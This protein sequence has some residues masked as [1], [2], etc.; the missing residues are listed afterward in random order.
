[1]PRPF[2]V[3]GFSS[4]FVLSLL[5]NANTQAAATAA[6]LIAAAFIISIIIGPVRRARVIP[7][8]LASCFVACILLLGA[9]QLEYKPSLEYAD[10]KCDLV[11]EIT[12][13]GARAYGRYYYKARAVSI[14]GKE[15]DVKIRLCFPCAL[16]AEPYDIVSGKFN[17]YKLG[18]SGEK[19]SDSLRASRVF[20][21]AY[22]EGEFSVS[23]VSKGDKPLAYRFHTAREAIKSKVY[24]FL[25]NESGAMAIALLLGDISGISDETLA[26][27][28]NVG[29]SHII[30]V[31][32]IHLSIWAMFLLSLAKKLRLGVKPASAVSGVIV[33]GYMALTGFPYS[34]IRAG[35][36]S[37][38][39]LGGNIISR[40]KDSLNSLGLAVTVILLINPF[41]AGDF[42]L[43]LSFL[44]T[45]GIICG[46]SAFSQKIHS[47]L[48]KLKQGVPLKLFSYIVFSVFTTLCAVAFTLPVTLGN[49]T[50]I[51]FI[52]ILANVLTLF[53]A[54]ACMVLSG[55]AAIISLVPFA[56]VIAYPEARLAGIF[57]DYIILVSKKLGT[58]DFLRFNYERD[59]AALWLACTLAFVA[60][61]ILLS[62][63]GKKYIGLTC[64]LV[65]VTFTAMLGISGIFGE[66]YT[67]VTVTDVGN[68]SAVIIS[69][70]G[71]G[72]LLGCGGDSFSASKDII[73]A[74]KNSSVI[75]LK[76][77]LIPRAKDY[78]AACAVD[79]LDEIKP[80]T[81]A[82]SDLPWGAELMLR[83]STLADVSFDKSQVLP[84]I[85]L[86]SVRSDSCCYAVVYIDNSEILISFYP[87]G[88]ILPCD[89]SA[90]ILICRSDVPK[91]L[92][93]SKFDLTVISGSDK[94]LAV[95][96]K[97]IKGGVNA[98]ATAGGGNIVLQT[99]GDGVFSASR[100]N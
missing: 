9:L 51:N 31:S 2:A 27:F 89:K 25:P 90:D 78:E 54:T 66:R 96:D 94:A 60:V 95:Q 56:R 50:S 6:A 98:A 77:L 61:S 20:I 19:S 23:P 34:V 53:A 82:C 10:K 33:L 42:S 67:R 49:E 16:E 8:S 74:L 11:C 85:W 59:I 3:I 91:C 71:E 57:A 39:F 28:R 13:N 63:R 81:V 29:I 30:S 48:N 69:K 15:A 37:L 62:Y 73:Y 79:V 84:G 87:G 64:A 80:R 38:V 21:G 1:M 17:T 75:S 36:M 41:A 45:L 86:K 55:T 70:G 52:S 47:L 46:Y 26:A 97:L 58:V 92:D 93:A 65:C 83:E 4:F 24:S 14:D 12:D 76:L 68:G 88:D 32:G 35:I 100:E 72:I 99:G 43:R 18:A 44:S 22:S 40:E 7:V 5:Y